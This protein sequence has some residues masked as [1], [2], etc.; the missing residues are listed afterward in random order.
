[1]GRGKSPL[2]DDSPWDSWP[3]FYWYLGRFEPLVGGR[4]NNVA[5]VRWHRRIRPRYGRAVLGV[6]FS[7]ML[8]LGSMNAASEGG[9]RWLW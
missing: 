7:S 9:C 2:D 5:T 4:G 3:I 6:A 8:G 1:M